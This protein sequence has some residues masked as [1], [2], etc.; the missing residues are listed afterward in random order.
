MADN[1]EASRLAER[2]AKRF[3]QLVRLQTP[4]DGLTSD[5]RIVDL[6]KRRSEA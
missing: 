5:I 6:A 2:A 1:T 4:V 3:L